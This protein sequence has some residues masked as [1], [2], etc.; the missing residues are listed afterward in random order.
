MVLHRCTVLIS[1][2]TFTGSRHDCRLD[3]DVSGVLEEVVER[4][5]ELIV[6]EC[7]VET[8]IPLL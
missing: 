4:S 8:C 7:P 1:V 3:E 6:E 5:V 2:G